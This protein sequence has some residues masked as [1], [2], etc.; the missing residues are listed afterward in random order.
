MSSL[1]N[2]WEIKDDKGTK[3]KFHAE[4]EDPLQCDIKYMY[5][6]KTWHYFYSDKYILHPNKWNLCYTCS[7]D[8]FNK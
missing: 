3:R 2:L 7:M 6:Y 8:K 1:L 4:E 5:K